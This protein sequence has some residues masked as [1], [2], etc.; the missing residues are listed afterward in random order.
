MFFSEHS[1]H[2]SDDDDDDDDDDV[3]VVVAVEFCFLYFSI[4]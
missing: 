4:K 1:V 3:F 2:L